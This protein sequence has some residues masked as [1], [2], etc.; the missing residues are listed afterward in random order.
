MYLIDFDNTFI[1]LC[2]E[3]KLTFATLYWKLTAQ[4]LKTLFFK[5]T[6]TKY[7]I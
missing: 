1:Y 3:F 7:K 6:C 2:Y 5:Y 4:D